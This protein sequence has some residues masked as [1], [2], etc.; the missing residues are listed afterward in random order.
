MEAAGVIRC[1]SSPWASP[2]HMVHKPDG[3]WRPFGDYHKLN[4]QTV[5]DWNPLPNVADFTSIWTVARF[6]PSWIWL[7]D[8]TVHPTKKKCPSDLRKVPIWPTIISIS[9]KIAHLTYTNCQFDLRKVP[10]RPTKNAHLT[11]EKCP[12]GLRKM[13]IEPTKSAHP[14]Y[15]NCPSA[16]RKMPIRLTKKAHQTI[17]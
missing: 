9:T 3:S 16:L 5:P 17:Y 8:F 7:R 13:P 14:T 1:L 11:Y 2:F 4:T 15:E 6:S 10:I 12:S